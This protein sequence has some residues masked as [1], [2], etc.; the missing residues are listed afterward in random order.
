MKTKTEK[1]TQPHY[2]LVGDYSYLKGVTAVDVRA[3]FAGVF[4]LFSTAVV[5]AIVLRVFGFFAFL[6][7]TADPDEMGLKT[8]GDFNWSFLP[9]AVPD[10]AMETFLFPGWKN[11]FAAGEPNTNVV[12]LPRVV[13][14]GLKVGASAGLPLLFLLTPT[15]CKNSSECSNKND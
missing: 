13:M 2:T 7:V 10:V 14:I 1:K 6:L 3:G 15:D 8:L 5:T 4:G 9:L 12:D 11:G